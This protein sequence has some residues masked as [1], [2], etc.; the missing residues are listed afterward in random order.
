V[1]L[2]SP[3]IS[4]AAEWCEARLRE[5]KRIEPWWVSS[6]LSWEE[7]HTE[8]RWVTS[9]LQARKDARA[10][11]SLPLV[12]EVDGHV[13][14]Q[15]GLEW[16]SA[17]TGVAEMGVWMDS[18]WAAR[19]VSAVVA[20]MMIDHAMTTLGVHRIIAPISEGNVAAAWGARK[21]GMLREGTMAGFL[22]VGGERR[23]HH[24]WALTSDRLPPGGLA[25]AMQV[26]ADQPRGERLVEPP[27]VESAEEPSA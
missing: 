20:G 27:L 26:I 2:R 17:A 11:R 5:Q 10:G 21:L 4:D 16:I 23:D 24:L 1:L 3:R 25:A 18:R 9:V 15:C 7:R 22:E 8:A 6:P 13:A 14:G 12:V 19:G